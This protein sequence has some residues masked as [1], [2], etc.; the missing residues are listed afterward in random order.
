[1]SSTKILCIT[2]TVIIAILFVQTSEIH[3]TIELP[4]RERLSISSRNGTFGELVEG[5]ITDH[6]KDIIL[7]ECVSFLKEFSKQAADFIKCSVVNARP[8]RFCEM[9]AEHYIKAVRVYQDIEHV[10]I[11]LLFQ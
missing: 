2:V 9:C 4:S 5:F 1:M 8:F 11:S 6:S 10:C 7:P 3:G